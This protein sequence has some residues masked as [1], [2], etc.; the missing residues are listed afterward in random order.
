MS[1]T[2]QTRVIP[3]LPTGIPLL[4]GEQSATRGRSLFRLTPLRYILL[5]FLSITGILS[6][7][8][9]RSGYDGNR[10]EPLVTR[11]L[12]QKTA[13]AGTQIPVTLWDGPRILRIEYATVQQT[14]WSNKVG[15]PRTCAHMTVLDPATG[16]PDPKYP[17]GENTCVDGLAYRIPN[18]DT[19][20]PIVKPPL[21]P[22][23]IHRR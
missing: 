14:G 16:A 7:N 21:H 4:P 10:I 1:G 19:P 13:K 11:V 20:P 3:A 6:W 23:R 5:S 18:A 12:L 22:H 9:W 2:A 15:P 17:Y 8:A